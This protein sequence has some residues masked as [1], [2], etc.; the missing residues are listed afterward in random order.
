MTFVSRAIDGDDDD[1]DGVSIQLQA[2]NYKKVKLDIHEI[3]G[4]LLNKKWRREPVTIR[5][6]APFMILDGRADDLQ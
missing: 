2:Y 5:N 1:G 6:F 4:R 3:T